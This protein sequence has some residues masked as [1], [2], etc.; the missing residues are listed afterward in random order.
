AI[1]SAWT[2]CH[3][4]FL[5][6]LAELYRSDQS[7]LSS[8]PLSGRPFPYGEEYLGTP[9]KIPAV[10]PQEDQGERGA[11]QNE[12]C[13]ALAK[14]LWKVRW[15]LLKKPSNL[16]V[17]EKQAITALESRDEGFVHRFRS[18]IRQL[19]NI[20]DHAHSEAQAK[21]RL[22]QLRKDIHAMED[23]HLEKI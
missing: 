4:G 22:Q 16:S 1:K 23:P 15:R 11:Q 5:G 8:R 20:F 21:L 12:G 2:Q 10:L 17:E 6:L 9:Q 3:R 19:V 14:Q 18:I 7:R 13:L